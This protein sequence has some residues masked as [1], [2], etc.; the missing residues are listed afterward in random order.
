MENLWD[1]QCAPEYELIFWGNS[2]NGSTTGGVIE[3]NYSGNTSSIRVLNHLDSVLSIDY[4][5]DDLYY[6][7]NTN[8]I[9]HQVFDVNHTTT[10]NLVNKDFFKRPFAVSVLDAYI[11][12]TDES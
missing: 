3:A 9:Y 8:E 10:P 12:V 11:Y 6:L 7:A 5:D 2:V 1:V 4:E